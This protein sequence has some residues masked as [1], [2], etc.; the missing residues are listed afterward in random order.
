MQRRDFIKYTAGNTGL[1]C[2][3]PFFPRM[4]SE[5]SGDAGSDFSAVDMI[6]VP[7][8]PDEW[9]AF[10]KKL[11]QWRTEARKKINYDDASYR[12]PEFQWAASAYNCYF[13]M[14][15]DEEFYDRLTHRYAVEKFLNNAI[16]DFGRLDTVVLW[17]AYPRIGLDDRNQFDFYRDMPGGLEGIREVCDYFHS[18][19]VKVFINY[20]P[21][22]TGTR[23]EN[24]S[25]IEA[26]AGIMK[27]INADGLFLDTLPNAASG[28]RKKLDNAGSGLILESEMSLPLEHIGEHHL[29][30]AQWF[31]DS[32]APGV[33]RNKWFEPRHIQHGISRWNIDRTKELHT[34]W[35]NGSGILIWENVFGQWLG[36]SKRDKWILR[37]ISPVQK[38]YSGL[39]SEGEWIPAIKASPE[40]GIYANLW[41]ND[42]VRLWTLVN[43][44]EQ[45]VDGRL[46]AVDLKADENYYDLIRGME[47]KP[48]TIHKRQAM[49]EG[50][51][52]A[53]NVGCFAALK[54]QSVD[55]AFLSFLQSQAEIYREISDESAFNRRIACL[56]PSAE[57]VQ[58]VEVPPEMTL[59]PAVKKKMRVSFR[60]RETGCYES[61]DNSFIDSVYPD[62]HQLHTIWKDA[63]IRRFAIDKM[64]VTNRQFKT[65]LDETAY[66]PVVSFN[67]LKHWINGNIPA[68]K[69][70]H[71]VVY[72][73]LDDARTYAA[74]A[75]KRLPSEEEW[76]YAAQGDS[77]NN[78]PWGNDP[79]AGRCNAGG[80]DTAPVN[81]YP[82]G[83]S[84]FGCYDLCGNVWEMTESEYSDGRNR[85][86]ILKGGSYYKAENSEW[87]FDGGALPVHFSAKQLLIYPGLDRC[88]TVGF[89]CAADLL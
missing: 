26:L 28:F 63:D 75:G 27:A 24:A 67:F 89:R 15:Y 7:E 13:L 87:Y 70:E 60:F 9:P 88:G 14:M 34:A 59:I 30:W 19:N 21:W 1:M 39:F 47:I 31:A 85:F 52:R 43:R 36:W 69:E 23:R 74:W 76:Q 55:A 49:L 29:S 78:Y 53:R 17:H 5:G 83:K 8:N 62:L 40:Q 11:L 77:D 16:R 81:R 20:N 71:P 45:N 41:R 38:R 51:I 37:A 35:M 25:D 73:D 58:S 82:E 32:R 84:T 2:L 6:P 64:P 65:F 68:G 46:L 10:R 3:F 54:K 12:N 22:D 72:V 48:L 18:E 4:N 42:S 56:K 80:T 50:S 66:R 86:C 33:L 57:T 44:S 79:D 61:L